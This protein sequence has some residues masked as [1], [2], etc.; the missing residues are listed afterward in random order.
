MKNSGRPT[1]ACGASSALAT[2]PFN[3]P[4]CTITHANNDKDQEPATGHRSVVGARVILLRSIFILTE[5]GDAKGRQQ[6][7]RSSEIFHLLN[8]AVGEGSLGPVQVFGL[9]LP[10]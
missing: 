1:S 8:L 5:C 6:N 4:V 10:I 3:D 7:N 9:A 2:S